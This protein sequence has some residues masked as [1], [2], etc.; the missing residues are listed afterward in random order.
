M[1]LNG[2]FLRFFPKKSPKRDVFKARFDAL[3]TEILQNTEYPWIKKHTLGI[4]GV[5]GFQLV[6]AL[7]IKDIEA[8]P[9]EVRSKEQVKALRKLKK[10]WTAMQLTREV[11]AVDLDATAEERLKEM[12]YLYDE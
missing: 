11:I 12:S 2:L 9:V 8:L 10:A 1:K 3:Y 5:L 6:W 7:L 4:Q